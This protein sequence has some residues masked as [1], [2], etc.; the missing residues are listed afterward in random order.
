MAA[1]S[2]TPDLSFADVQERYRT[3]HVHRLHPYL[4]K[5]IPQLVEF[6][7]KRH[8]QPG[9]TI[10]DPFV[11]SGT[12]LV[13]ANVL[14]INAVGI[15][16]S[17]WNC[18]IAEVKTAHYD[19]PLLEKE[20]KDALL[21]TEAFSSEL[22]VNGSR[23][24]LATPEAL[25]LAFPSPAHWND[26]R[27]ETDSQY[28]KVWL[29][30]RA[31]QE[32]LF[33]RSIIPDYSHHKV[34]QVILSR[35]TRSARLTPHYDLARP[36]R[37]IYE[38]YYCIK[39][40]RRCAPID[41]AIKFIRRY[42]LDTVRRIKEFAQQRS[43]ADIQIHCADAREFDYGAMVFDG[44]FTSPPYVGMIDYH[45][46]HRYAYELFPDLLWNSTREIGAMAKGQGRQ[47][48]DQYLQDIA[49][50]LGRI[51]LQPGAPVF[52]VAN[53]RYQLYP[54][55]AQEAG[56]E[57]VSVYHRLV[58]KRTERD[59]VQY[60]ESVFYLRALTTGRRIAHT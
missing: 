45:E 31:R 3:K 29:S 28:L 38:E 58:L 41:N 30:E 40:R 5:F 22:R 20:I 32:A 37:P 4:G 51:P 44:V 14:G 33:Y 23:P 8:F 42:S 57:L 26:H 49:M 18:L 59:N 60:S 2:S 10:L 27:V 54:R 19:L 6:F 53:D 55:I 52:I 9:Q 16:I 12:T 47:A 1:D 36:K 39:H 21:R 34:L 7:L 48:R 24:A 50:V 15:E 35:A 17:E 56:L 25:P 46:Q 11:G 13:E 43:P